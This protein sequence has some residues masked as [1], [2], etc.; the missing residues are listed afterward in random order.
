MLSYN[1]GC[2]ITFLE[3][4]PAEDSGRSAPQQLSTLYGANPYPCQHP[5]G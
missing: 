5:S 2:S 4:L 1:C 3:K